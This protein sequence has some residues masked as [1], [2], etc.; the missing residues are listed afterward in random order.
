MK[1]HKKGKLGTGIIFTALIAIVVIVVLFS[2][3]GSLMPT[4]MDAG[5]SL[6]TSESC[7]TAG[8]NYNGTTAQCDVS[9]SVHTICQASYE[10][11][12]GNLFAGSG[13][14]FLIIMASFLFIIVRSYL[15]GKK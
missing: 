1:Q 5:D 6:N 8:C 3:L 15:G 12:L 13:F 11:P 10:S 2:V 4:A 14:I 9:T 7:N